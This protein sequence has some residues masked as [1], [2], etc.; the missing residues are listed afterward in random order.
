MQL[1]VNFVL[2]ILTNSHDPTACGQKDCITHPS[3]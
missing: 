2:E 3:R 1:E